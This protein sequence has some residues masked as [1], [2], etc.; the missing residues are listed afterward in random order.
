MA[1]LTL[2]DDAT[3]DGGSPISKSTP[4]GQPTVARARQV[5][6]GDWKRPE[7]EPKK[8][9]RP[10]ECGSAQSRQIVYM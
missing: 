9:E 5:T 1:S 10:H 6:I 4:A 7:Q 2:G 3:I 8:P